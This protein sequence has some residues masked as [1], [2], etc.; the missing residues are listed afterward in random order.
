MRECRKSA[1][2][3]RI[4]CVEAWAAI[5]VRSNSREEPPERCEV[6]DKLFGAWSDFVPDRIKLSTDDDVEGAEVSVLDREVVE[7]ELGTVYQ[8]ERQGSRSIIPLSLSASA[9]TML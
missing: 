6:T 7:V 3:C 2:I 9:L 5:K 8:E 1:D 4:G